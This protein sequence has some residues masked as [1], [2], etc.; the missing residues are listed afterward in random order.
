MTENRTPIQIS[1]DMVLCADKSLWKYDGAWWV[2]LAPIP[3]DEDYEVLKQE[4]IE[5]EREWIKS[6]LEKSL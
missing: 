5:W 4:R 1:G 2:K 3:T 6:Q